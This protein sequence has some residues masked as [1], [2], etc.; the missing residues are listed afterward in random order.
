MAA[1]AS[2]PSRLSCLSRLLS[3]HRLDPRQ[4]AAQ[5]A[6]LV[7]V[8]ELSHRL[9]DPHPEQLISQIALLGAQVVHAQIAQLRGLHDTF[10]CAKRVAN[11]VAIGSFAEASRIASRASFSLTPSISKSTRPGL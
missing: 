2:C 10:S 3:Q 7:R 1:G 6:H 9:L 8:L 5:A 4:I 11:F